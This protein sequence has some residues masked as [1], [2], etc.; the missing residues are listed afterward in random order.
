M[1]LRC[2]SIQTLLPWAIT[3]I[4]VFV[5]LAVMPPNKSVQRTNA[6]C[7]KVAAVLMGLKVLQVA[8]PVMARAFAA[9][10]SRWADI[11]PGRNCK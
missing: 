11:L 2:G 6:L 10:A 3:R 8:L 5:L 9:N 1:S 7:A 4:T